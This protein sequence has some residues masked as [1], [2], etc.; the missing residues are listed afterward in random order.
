MLSLDSSQK[1]EGNCVIQGNHKPVGIDPVQ[2]PQEMR[3]TL[4]L[5]HEGGVYQA[6]KRTLKHLPQHSWLNGEQDNA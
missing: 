5:H 4:D 6:M 3:W 1:A 2:Y